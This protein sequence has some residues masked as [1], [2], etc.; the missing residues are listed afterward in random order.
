MRQI[1]FWVL[2]L[3]TS[4][5]ALAQ[6]RVSTRSIQRWYELGQYERLITVYEARPYEFQGEKL[7]YLA[8]AYYQLGRYQEAYSTYK[9]AFSSFS[10]AEGSHHLAFARL[11]HL[12]GEAGSA[13]FHYRLA[14]ERGASLEEAQVGLAQLDRLIQAKSD[15]TYQVHRVS[16]GCSRETEGLPAPTYGAYLAEGTLYYIHRC[17]T[18]GTPTCWLDGYPHEQVG[19]SDLP[20]HYRYHQGVVGF[21]PPDTLLIYLSRRKGGIY[22]MTRTAGETGWTRPKRWKRLPMRPRGQY[23]FCEDPKTGDLYFV[24]DHGGRSRTGRDIYRLRALENGTYSRPE[25]LPSPFNTPYDEDAP[26]VV[27]DTL[28]FS[29]RSTNS[30]GGYDIF[31][32]VR[33]GER[34]WSIPQAMSIPVNSP[35]DEIYYYPFSPEQTYFSSSRSG[36]MQV[37]QVRHVM[38]APPMPLVPTT[39][40]AE[41]TISAPRILS[42]MGRIYD[43]HTQQGISA[44]L[45]LVDSTSQK[46]LLGVYAGSDGQYRFY[47]PSGGV[48]YL[49]IQAPGYMTYVQVLH[50]PHEVPEKPISLSIPLFP[51]EMESTFQLRNIY[52]DFDSDRL[53]PES[54]PELQRLLRLLRENPH[55][56]IRFSGHTDNIGA[57]AYNKKL[58]ERRARA[59]YEWLKAQGTHP[60]Q[61]EFIGYGKARPITSNAT[62]EGRSLN[63][64]IEMEVVGIRRASGQAAAPP[65]GR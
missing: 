64:R 49:Y 33:Q 43:A 53:R 16:L 2:C 27:G 40:V 12:R 42:M 17:K 59:V 9:Q 5:Q 54:I 35:A 21:R 56:R 37:Y 32:A 47:P 18:P 22:Y 36:V 25:R 3:S 41:S 57:D 45:I 50:L 65:I 28:Y 61:M 4:S 15:T 63:R 26:F 30:I 29:S 23:S 1:A 11:L 39:L 19:E 24:S 52:F 62:E 14:L 6:K 31:F 51:I 44:Q 55:I 20:T 38:P 60:I 46:E 48:F 8:G 7:F 13:R 58:S 10:E 34:E